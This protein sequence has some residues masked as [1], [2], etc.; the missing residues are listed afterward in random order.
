MSVPSGIALLLFTLR[1]TAIL[2]SGAVAVRILRRRSAASR[3]AALALTVAALLML[4]ILSA[5]LPRIDLPVLPAQAGPDAGDR[6]LR[7][8]VDPAP[9]GAVAEESLVQPAGAVRSERPRGAGASDSSTLAPVVPTAAAVAPPSSAHSPVQPQRPAVWTP[10]AWL[11]LGWAFGFAIGAVQVV[12]AALRAHRVRRQAA[13]VVDADWTAAVAEARQAVGVH[14]PVALL[15]SGSVRVPVVHGFR[16]PVILLPATA[17]EWSPTRRHALLVHELAHIRRQDW[18]VQMLAHVARAF[19]WPNPLAWWAVRRLRAEAELACDDCV[20]LAGAAAPDYADDLLQAAR[21]LQDAPRPLAVLAVV[22]RSRLEDRLL[23]ILDPERARRG[24]G[25]RRLAVAGG[26]AL[27][28]A[29]CLVSLHPVTRVLAS[30]GERAR[31]KT[32]PADHAASRSHEGAGLIAPREDSSPGAAASTAG[33]TSEP[34]ASEAP[35]TPDTASVADDVDSN[36]YIPDSDD[37]R[38]DEQVAALVPGDVPTAVSA[39]PPPPLASGRVL[40]VIRI[41]TDLVQIDAVVTDKKGQHVRDLRPEDIEVFED[42]QRQRVTHLEYVVTGGGKAAAGAVPAAPPATTQAESRTLVFVV[43]DIGLSLE[44]SARARRMLQAFA[45]S[46]LGPRDRVAIVEASEVGRSPFLLTSDPAVFAAAADAV[47]YRVWSRAGLGGEPALPSDTTFSQGAAT[48]RHSQLAI[49]SLRA[50]KRVVDALRGVSGRKAVIVLSE[51][52]TTRVS[53]DDDHL[54]QNL[55]A[56]PLDGLYEDTGM[57]AALHSLTDL[58]NR[59]SVVL[60]ALDPLGLQAGS[61]DMQSSSLAQGGAGTLQARAGDSG[62]W[63]VDSRG[64]MSELQANSAARMARQDSLIELA[65]ETGGLA[66]V[67]NNDL[68]DGLNR[69]LAD[70]AGYYLIGYTPAHATFADPSGRPQFH[71]LKVVVKRPDTKVRS[72]KGFYGVTDEAVNHKAPAPKI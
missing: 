64:G 57:R 30:S 17:G 62:Y 22:E 53:R 43:D 41:S 1:A 12:R 55:T 24:V 2:L 52:F 33:P 10:T 32:P 29:A 67:E 15:A 65:S 18:L 8:V 47:R 69:I 16:R 21:D 26:L 6:A 38:S 28:A 72:R 44:S 35:A 59:A 58:A 66:V 60:Y 13:E 51:G 50:V 71:E 48:S 61:L 5:L 19:Y 3:H 9:R 56:L 63:R 46:G 70:Q 40:P 42:G 7:P 23:A 20:L 14:R 27:V 31:P 34:L 11:V 45:G 25:A 4:P 37:D 39:I 68:G 36:D 54:L 49:D